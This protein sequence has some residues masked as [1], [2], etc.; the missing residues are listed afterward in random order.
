[1][2]IVKNREDLTRYIHHRLGA[3]TVK[4]SD[5]T[6]E[7]LDDIIDEA[8][9]RFY[10][11]A[12]GFAQEEKILYLPVEKGVS[13]YDISGL[14]RKVSAVRE[15]TGDSMS[16]VNW[17]NFNRLFT[18]E[19]MIVNRF[20]FNMRTPDI[21]TYQTMHMWLDTFSMLYGKMYRASVN[22]HAET[23]SILPFPE[24]DGAMMFL[25]YVKRPEED[26]FNYS[27]IKDYIFAK[28]LIQVGMNRSKYSGI[29]LPGGGTLNGDMYL[30]KGEDMVNK[31]T[32]QLYNEWSEPPDFEMA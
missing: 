12:I 25:V 16:S 28:C 29:A 9:V 24:A 3:P 20:A 21:L 5:L 26:I 2:A 4:T 22:E 13:T 14:D 32:D 31:L 1:M 15:V 11:H 18:I 30:S 8:L 23:I 6:P 19:N 10:E 17:K 7:Q 27:W